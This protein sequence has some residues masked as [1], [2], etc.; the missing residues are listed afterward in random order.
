MKC[1]VKLMLQLEMAGDERSPD[2][3]IIDCRHEKFENPSTLIGQLL[4]IGGTNRVEVTVA[5]GGYEQIRLTHPQYTI[6][7][8]YL[9]AMGTAWRITANLSTF[10]RDRTYL[11]SS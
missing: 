10:G 8:Y 11:G 1:G 2:A 6:T 3:V 4:A 5:P 7:P 9:D